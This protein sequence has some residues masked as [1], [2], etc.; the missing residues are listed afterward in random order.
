MIV[1]ILLVIFSVPLVSVALRPGPKG[2]SLFSLVFTLFHVFW[3]L[4]WSVGVGVLVLLF[5]VLLVGREVVVVRSDLMLIRLDLL[6][7]GVGGEYE[8]WGISNLRSALPD[9]AKGSSWRGSHLAFDYYSIPVEFGSAVVEPRA[10]EILDLVRSKLALSNG[11]PDFSV[12]SQPLT[13]N[14]ESDKRADW[15]ESGLDPFL[16]KDRSA[17]TAANSG[18]GASLSSSSTKALILANLVPLA[19]VWLLGWDIGEI[20]LLY[21]AE[22]GIIGFFTLLKMVVVGRW[23]T[24]FYGP[25]FI[26][27]YGAFMAGHLLFVFTFFVQGLEA[28]G[29]VTV[30]EVVERFIAL[31]PALLALVVSHGFSFLVNFLG[32]REFTATTVQKQMAEPYSRIMIMHLT[33]ILG[34]FLVMGLGSSLPAL[35]LLMVAKIGV[36]LRSHT[37]QHH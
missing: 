26:G 16:P 37:R 12:P 34:G 21:W 14:P 9:A 28:K 17:K 32:R 35:L 24:L 31:W 6:G 7:V 13:I 29:S 25:F 20:M 23:S 18:L 3:G 27:H 30:V 15:T 8:A 36:D 2:D 33:I 19:G 4:G 1:G 22:S 5:L 11:G 10:S